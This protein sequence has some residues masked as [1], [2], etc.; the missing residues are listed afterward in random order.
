[1]KKSNLNSLTPLSN[2][3]SDEEYNEVMKMSNKD[4]S[5][6]DIGLKCSNISDSFF[7]DAIKMFE[8]SNIDEK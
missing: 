3:V 5:I 1:M 2:V 6:D 7:E 4:I 8:K